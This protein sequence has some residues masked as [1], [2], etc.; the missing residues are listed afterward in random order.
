MSAVVLAFPKPKRRRKVVTRTEPAQIYTLRM[1][2]AIRTKGLAEQA[3]RMLDVVRAPETPD[4]MLGSCLERARVCLDR[5]GVLA[6][7]THEMGRLYALR[8]HLAHCEQRLGARA[9]IA[10]ELHYGALCGQERI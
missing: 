2:R 9:A 7:D 1:E 8:W 6:I 4:S 3:A 5:A 10:A